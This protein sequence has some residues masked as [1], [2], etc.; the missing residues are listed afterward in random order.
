MGEEGLLENMF[1]REIL[2]GTNERGKLL[3]MWEKEIGAKYIM[4]SEDYIWTGYEMGISTSA[5]SC[6]FFLEAGKMLSIMMIT[7]KLH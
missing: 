5:I 2:W 3:L 6:R 7:I 1:M 4:T